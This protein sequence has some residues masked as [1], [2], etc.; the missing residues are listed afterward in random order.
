MSAFCK[1]SSPSLV[2][3]I[4]SQRLAHVSFKMLGMLVWQHI[5]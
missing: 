5:L 3:A 4:L 1:H 2:S